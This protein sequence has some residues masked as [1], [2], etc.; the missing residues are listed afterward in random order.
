VVSCTWRA[1]CA[2]SVLWLAATAAAAQ[3]GPAAS[4]PAGS[5]VGFSQA[6]EAAIGHDP[7]FRSARHERDASQGNVAIARAQLLPQVSLSVSDAMTR[8]VREFPNSFNQQVSVQLEYQ[9][10][11]TA[12]QLRAPLFNFESLTRYRQALVQSDAADAIF[13]VR[14]AE[15]VERLATNYMQGLLMVE[16]AR[17]LRAQIA[18]LE[19]QQ[20][21]AEQR[22]LRGEGSRIEV[23]DAKAQLELARVRLIDTLDQ[24]NVARRALARIT[25]LDV[26]L[27][28]GVPERFEPPPLLP[29]QLDEWLTLA[30]MRNAVVQVREKQLEV[31]RLGVD[32][33]RAGHFPRLDAVASVSQSSNDSV[34]S[35]NQSSRLASVGL[36]LSV[37]LYSGG[38]VDAGVRQ[39]RSEVAKAEADLANEREQVAV[40]LQ[41]NYMAV[42]SGTARLQA[43]AQAVAANEL[44]L[45]GV[46]RGQAAGLRTLAEVQEATA[47]LFGARR[48]LGQARLDYLL[49]RTRLH[50]LSG[51]PLAEVVFDIERLLGGQP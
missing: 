23:A 46:S 37:P 38:G 28:R 31:A 21:R 29:A 33:A 17:Q 39:A 47:R 44:V 2:G 24:Q 27:Q 32:R 25:G 42:S 13:R 4:A 8:G 6:F 49:A 19:V 50:L 30:R 20:Q 45:E 10:P 1:L 35:L 14:G 12:L 5:T 22:L 9:A 51:A 11:Q 34:S 15:L 36:Q 48:E 3:S 16:N 18:S 43:M 41:R 26:P 7:Q 40:E